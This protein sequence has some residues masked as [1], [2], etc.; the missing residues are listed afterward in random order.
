MQ[1]QFLEKHYQRLLEVNLRHRW[2]TPVIAT[3][4][5]ASA[6]FPFL[7]TDMNFDAE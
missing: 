3:V 4:V 5:F 7:R 2:L 6:A 1:M